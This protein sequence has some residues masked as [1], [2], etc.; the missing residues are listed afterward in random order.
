MHRPSGTWM[1]P[2]NNPAWEKNKI[3]R[4]LGYYG[5]L[6][7]M[8]GHGSDKYAQYEAPEW[9]PHITNHVSEVDPNKKHKKYYP[10]T[11]KANTCTQDGLRKKLTQTIFNAPF[12]SQSTE[13]QRSNMK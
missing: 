6:V 5:V 9:K 4:E 11:K 3:D 13:I 12:L 1:L 8:G 2:T 10:S 7:S